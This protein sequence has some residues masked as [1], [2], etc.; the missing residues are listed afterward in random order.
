MLVGFR[1]DASH[2]IG[3]GHVMR[4][5]T[6]AK[7]L[8]SKGA[9]CIFI[10]RRTKSN[11]IS[12]LRKNGFDVRELREIED[13]E[14]TIGK[15]IDQPFHADWLGLNWES[16]ALHTIESLGGVYLDWLVVDHYAID[17]K[18]EKKTI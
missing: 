18:W 9:T 12:L 3:T 4:C 1:V 17:I 13:N 16:D 15:Q 6:L 7:D 8:R 11:L 2:I 10:S 5:L 14:S